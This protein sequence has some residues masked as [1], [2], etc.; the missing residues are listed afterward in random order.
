MEVTRMRMLQDLAVR[1]EA[2]EN[3]LQALGLPSRR[4]C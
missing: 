2:L 3:Q 4:L 1:V